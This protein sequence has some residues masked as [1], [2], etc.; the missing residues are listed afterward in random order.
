MKT[1]I[2]PFKSGSD[3]IQTMIIVGIIGLLASMAVPN[4]KKKK[5]SRKSG[6]TL[7]E[8]MITIAIIGLLAAFVIRFYPREKDTCIVRLVRIQDAKATFVL[9]SGKTNPDYVVLPADIY[10]PGKLDPKPTCPAGGDYNINAVG[11]KPTCSKP[12]HV[13]PSVETPKIPK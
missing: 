1:K 5:T 9:W 8:I 6:Y 13:L 12:R 4:A 10:G 2:A 7:V 11:K 3:L